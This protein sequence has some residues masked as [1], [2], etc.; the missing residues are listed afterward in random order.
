MAEKKLTNY[1]END[2]NKKG[3]KK[4]TEGFKA[5]KKKVH[6]S[7]IRTQQAIKQELTSRQYVELERYS[8]SKIKKEILEIVSRFL[9]DLKFTERDCD[10]KIP[11]PYIIGDFALETFILSEKQ[12]L[13]PN[14]T[15]ER[16]AIAINKN[17][18]KFVKNA[19]AVGP[20]V[21]IEVNKENLYKEILSEVRALKESYGES[22]KNA[23]K[24]VL[25]DFS[26]PNI[27]KPMGV[28]HLRSTIIGQALCNIYHKTGY[29][30]IRD[31]HLGDWGTQFGSLIWAYRHWGND[32]RMNEDPIGELKDLYVRFHEASEQDPRLEDEAR[33]IFAN[34]EQKDP[35]L[36]SLWKKF[37]DLSLV[38]FEKIYRRLGINFDTCIGESYFTEDSEG[39]IQECLKKG[40]CRKDERTGAVVVDS[41]KG[42]P[43]FLL[44]K[45]DGSSLYITRDLAALRF[46]VKIFKPET[47]LYVVG[48]EQELYFKQL[49]E[50]AKRV[51]YLM[52]TTKAKHIDFGMVLIGG[53]KMSTR[54]GTLI[55]LENFFNESVKVSK[56]ILLQKKS[57]LEPKEFEKTA[58]IIGVGAILYNDLNQSR[59]KNISF[60]WKQ[61]LDLEGGSAVYLQY[62]Y[63]RIKSILRKLKETH[64]QNGGGL[65]N[66]NIVF[67]KDIEFDLAKKIM[68]FPE[69]I[70]IAQETDS[71]HHICV[72]LEELAKS[73]NSF[74]NDVPVIHTSNSDL[75]ASRILLITTVALII[76][77]GLA[78]FNIRVPERM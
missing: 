14:Q 5:Y 37:R 51:K 75:R 56:E 65:N 7:I 41:I 70:L 63:A 48:K 23:G 30:V 59:I 35:E 55:E 24:V 16:I 57:D 10:L 21:N 27:A 6:E 69:V 54:K 32:K 20:F 34:L 25:V 33:Q 40:A 13:D 50:L 67:R 73:L 45:S 22:N 62:T 38:V 77:N 66:G 46:R 29:S 1:D 15:A 19:L 3:S 58:E 11:P 44:Q 52:A 76:K 36:S 53:K 28:G 72:Y 18:K 43:S 8:V 71:P 2:R 12:G 17:K 78:L 68:M 60:D 9:S 26:A 74:Y 31:N 49:F 39:I 64:I 61:M 42:I 47:I 4:K